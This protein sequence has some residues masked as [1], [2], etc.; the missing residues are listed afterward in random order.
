M[1]D[2]ELE[3]KQPAT[4]AKTGLKNPTQM[5]VIN[6]RPNLEHLTLKLGSRP[7]NIVQRVIGANKQ[8]RH[9]HVHG[10]DNVE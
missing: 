8:F 3:A 5:I 4:L 6:Y 10:H 1:A 9:N 7:R 2:D